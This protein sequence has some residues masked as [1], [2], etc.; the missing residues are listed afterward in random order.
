M[1][2]APTNDRITSA[3]ASIPFIDFQEKL[4]TLLPFFFCGHS[5]LNGRFSFSGHYGR[6]HRP[7][8]GRSCL[9]VDGG[10]SFYTCRSVYRRLDLPPFCRYR[11]SVSIRP[12]ARRSRSARFT[13][14]TDRCR[15]CAIVGI[16]GQHCPASLARSDRYRYT[17]TAR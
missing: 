9:L 17:E 4:T 14:L 11:C 5:S 15:S 6:Y 1:D 13:V 12:A 16:A 10:F 3:N 7:A 2:G 8:K